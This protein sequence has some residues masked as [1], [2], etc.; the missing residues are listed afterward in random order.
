M[1]WLDDRL[2]AIVAWS[3]WLIANVAFVSAQRRWGVGATGSW[4]PWDWHTWGATISPF[5][6]LLAHALATGALTLCCA[7]DRTPATS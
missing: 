2:V 1:Q 6:L 3:S 7:T 4:Y 5:A